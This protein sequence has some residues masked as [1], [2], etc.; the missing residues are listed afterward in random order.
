MVCMSAAI[1]Y[2]LLSICTGQHADESGQHG[3]VD[4]NS[5][6][7]SLRTPTPPDPVYTFTQVTGLRPKALRIA[8]TTPYVYPHRVYEE[9]L[10][11]TFPQVRGP[12]VHVVAGE[13][14]EPSK[15]SRWIYSPKAASP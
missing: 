15:L 2:P 10:R 6:G 4:P 7:Y 9:G 11:T 1:A 13:G 5:P 3:G 12:L 8:K 14:F